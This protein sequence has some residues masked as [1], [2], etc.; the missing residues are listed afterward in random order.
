MAINFIPNDPRASAFNEVISRSARPN[1]GQ[2]MAGF[3]LPFAP[4]Q[5]RYPPKTSEFVFWQSREAA[6]AAVEAYEE[7][8]GEKL[9]RWARSAPPSK[10]RLEPDES[11]EL[12]AYYDRESVSFSHYP[13]GTQIIYSGASTDVVAHEVGHAILD[14]LRPD[15]W[16]IPYLEAGAFHEAFGDCMA[17]LTSLYDAKVRGVL[18]SN[19]MLGKA[20]FA[21][22]TSEELA[23]AIGRVE[24]GH[25]AS[26]PRKAVNKY[27]WALPSTLPSDGAP[28]TLINEVHS[29]G[30]V[31]TG[32]FYD[33]ILLVYEDADQ[34][35]PSGLWRAVKIAGQLLFAAARA[36]PARERFFHAL[37]QSFVEA[38]R[39]L[40]DSAHTE[41]ITEAFG[42]H[43]ID[44]LA[45]PGFAPRSA[46]A[47]AARRGRQIAPETV[48]DVRERLGVGSKVRL[49][50]RDIALGRTQRVEMCAYRPVDLTGLAGYLSGVRAYAAEPVVVGRSNGAM[51][52]LS[53]IPDSTAVE[54]EARV[55]VEGLVA[56]GQ[57]ERERGRK[58]K[59]VGRGS[60]ETREGK[61]LAFPPT[62]H[63]IARA[64]E[65][66]LERVRF[67]CGCCVGQKHRL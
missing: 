63:V 12:N 4:Q 64:G 45:A 50:R 31:F 57:I 59:A 5:K 48:K 19:G 2:G 40:F 10:L 58:K 52:M 60:R 28:G 47:G 62:H 30:Q 7:I 51:A 23:W 42:R 13:V 3:E 33:L 36:A 25:S 22:T 20:N 9:K 37:A 1:R 39:E 54:Q 17:I 18:T 56:H 32:C 29:F 65:K 6:L 55:F 49:D 15:L 66:V 38:D 46:L 43:N 67:A 14:V 53:G 61:R 34:R 11:T 44:I 21:E 26:K 35:T 24:P 8:S 16:D 27:Q 41:A